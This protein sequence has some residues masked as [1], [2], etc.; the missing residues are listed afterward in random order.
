MDFFDNLDQ[1]SSQEKKW[2]NVSSELES[3]D[4][5]KKDIKI[6]LTADGKPRA[7]VFFDID[8]TLAHLSAIHGK[9]IAKLFPDQEPKELEETYYKGFKLGNS[10]REFDRMR[11]IYIDGHVEW[12]DPEV[13]LKERFNSHKKEIDEPRH[14]AHN[15]AAA[16]L[17]EYGKVA[18]QI[19]DDIYK[20]NPEEF[21]KA[22]IAPIFKLAEMYAR[23]GIP[24][25]G[26]TANAK[27]FVD[28]LAKYLKLSEIFL[29]IAT[30]ETM[31]GGGK[32]I[33]IHHLINEMEK[34]GLKM[35]ERR[36]IFVGDSLR[37]DIG[38]S[39]KARE[40]NEGIFGQG[41]LVLEDTKALIEMEKQI[42]EN[43]ELRR[44][45]DEM[46]RDDKLGGV[47]GFVVENV[48]LDEKGNPVILA[49]FREKFLKKL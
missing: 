8:G 17:E 28:K 27:I 23:L 25:V 30:D 39:I 14:S 38:T 42:N 13:Y 33:A 3:V 5:K 41:I 46:N 21:E 10:F 45:I 34:K 35:P 18:A 26:F 44:I 37:G 36:M 2:I 24:M 29:D 6:E 16:I 48:P 22:N 49:R 47:Y 31:A 1:I 43:P 32:E 4:G 12:K 40:K 11:G 20:K 9:A 15:I 19:C 7:V